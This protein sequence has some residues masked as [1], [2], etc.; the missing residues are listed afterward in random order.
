MTDGEAGETIPSILQGY[1]ET[2]TSAYQAYEIDRSASNLERFIL[3]A[4]D[5]L[6]ERGDSAH[7]LSV[8]PAETR[9]REDLNADSLV[10]AEFVFLLEDLFGIVLD[11]EEIE[12]V[13]TLGDLQSLVKRKSGVG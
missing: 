2:V 5:F 10:L 9:L 13:R 7:P 8:L 3:G 1:P 6:L 4:I 11:N 12:K